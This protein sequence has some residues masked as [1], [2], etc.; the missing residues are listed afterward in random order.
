M[1]LLL[2]PE[3]LANG[4]AQAPAAPPPLELQ[5]AGLFG[6]AEVT[7]FIEDV[8]AGEQTFAGHDPPDALLHQGHAV[9]Q[10]GLLAIADRLTHPQQEA[11]A[12]WQV[13]G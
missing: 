3:V 9:E 1:E 4:Q 10:I 13:T 6:R 7:P 8:V 12:G 11:L 2:H 5:Q